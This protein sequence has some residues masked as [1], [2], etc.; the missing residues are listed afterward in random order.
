MSG[1]TEKNHDLNQGSQPAG[2]EVN[3]GPPKHEVGVVTTQMQC[4]MSWVQSIIEVREKFF[5]FIWTKTMYNKT[6]KKSTFFLKP[7]S[8]NVENV[9]NT[10]D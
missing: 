7:Q 3:M 1:G 5:S 10:P 2:W 4:S 6:V 9:Y 8:Y